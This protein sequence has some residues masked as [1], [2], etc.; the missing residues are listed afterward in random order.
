MNSLL[1]AGPQL[2]ELHAA[3]KCE[4]ADAT[5]L[6]EGQPPFAP[7]R[8]RSLDLQRVDGAL[9]PAVVL[10]LADARLQPGMSRFVLTTADMRAP[11]AFDAVANAVVARRRLSY[12]RL[13]ECQLSPAVT[14]ALAR[15][16]RDGALTG[17]EFTSCE[18]QFAGEATLC[19]ALRASSTLTSLVLEALP[20]MAAAVVAALLGALAAHRSLRRLHLSF[21]PLEMDAAASAALGALVAADAPA[22]TEL[23]VLGCEL[24]EAGLSALLDAL[25]S[26][27]HLQQLSM[28]YNNVP[29][30][31]MRARLLPAVRGNAS[32]RTLIA[33]DVIYLTMDADE[34]NGVAS[35]EAE[36]IVE[37]R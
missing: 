11:G 8:L 10:A 33:A 29:A 13:N 2:R 26:N 19:E 18:G 23:D 6:L 12:L 21:T 4:L 20:T 37:A 14:P 34:D 30:G 32:L 24:G 27:S 15:A 1:A 16:L 17:L 22:L 25:P 28:R 31:F 36:Q 3:V 9:P 35:A 7:L 5:G